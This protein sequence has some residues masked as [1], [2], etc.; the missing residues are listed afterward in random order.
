VKTIVSSAKLYGESAIDILRKSSD[1]KKA[2]VVASQEAA[3]NSFVSNKEEK[4]KR[5][6]KNKDKKRP[7]NSQELEENEQNI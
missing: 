7:G 4:E 2:D 3:E 6:K 5:K 1:T